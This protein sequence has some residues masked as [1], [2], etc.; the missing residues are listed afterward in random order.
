MQTKQTLE[1]LFTMTALLFALFIIP[2]ST[3]AD[4]VA[5][6][7]QE[8]VRLTL[9]PASGLAPAAQTRPMAIVHVSIHDAVNGIT[10]ENR[11]YLPPSPAPAGASPEAAA[12]AAAHHALRNL[13]P[14]SA[15]SLDA[16][17]LSS[18]A[19]NG[20][21]PSDP[22]IAYGQWAAA[23]IF[24]ARSGDGAASAQ[25][26]YTAPRAGQ[27]GVW[28][29][30]TSAPAL[31]PGWGEVTPWVLQSNT[32]FL[33]PPPPSIHSEQYANDYNEIKSI[34]SINSTPRTTEQT[35]I[36]TFWRGSPT[37]IWNQ[38]LRQ[39]IAS[40][41]LSL[42]ARAR[43]YA[44]VY[45]SVAD[46]AII[47]WEAKYLYNNWRPQP[48]I[49]RGAEDRNLLTAPDTAWTP[50][51]AT[52]PHPEYPSG[53]T[54][55]SSAMA[56]IM[57]NAF[58][59]SPGMPISSTIGS[60]NRQWGSFTDGVNEVIDARVYSGIHF[61]NSDEVGADAGTEIANYVWAHA[62]RPCQGGRRGCS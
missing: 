3:R 13:F 60:I 57:S 34:G 28:V 23:S 43:I 37:D 41:N 46:A 2:I 25:Y 49:R 27:P 33:P 1:Q 21:S 26:N 20:L 52:P 45:L 11:T 40:R 54:M 7:N 17:F 51:F 10:R 58:G 56:V 47:C 30:L 42:S 48:A 39:L 53:H 8:A 9:L 16:M 55:N 62:L 24:A 29:L 36:A 38:P 18:L 4:V 19:A 44:L 6:W 14:N 32:Q 31:L 35:R 12:I 22:G 15:A 59:E 50:L 5:D 61:R